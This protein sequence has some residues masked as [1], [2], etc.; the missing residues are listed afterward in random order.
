MKYSCDKCSYS[1]RDKS[2]Y[3]RH[4]KSAAHIQVNT[5][6]TSNVNQTDQGDQVYQAVQVNQSI[7]EITKEIKDFICSNCNKPFS[8]KQS[9]SRHKLH[10]CFDKPP[11]VE[12]LQGQVKILST[13]V[14]NYVDDRRGLDLICSRGTKIQDVE[15]FSGAPRAL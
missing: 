6:S 12:E 11:K 1:T 4:M 7:Q 3:N 14:E 15:S 2:N 13:K 5:K 10:Y 9:L 8:C